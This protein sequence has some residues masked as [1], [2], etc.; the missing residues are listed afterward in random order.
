MKL[1]TSKLAPCLFA[2]MDRK[3]EC[4]SVEELLHMVVGEDDPQ[5]GAQ[6]SQSGADLGRRRLDALD[7]V[8]ILGLRHREELRGMRQHRSADHA[9]D[10]RPPPNRSSIDARQPLA[11]Q[12]AAGIDPPA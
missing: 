5:I 4:G 6:R 11:I 9:L 2:D 10:H 7:R 12:A 3:G 1:A 8:A